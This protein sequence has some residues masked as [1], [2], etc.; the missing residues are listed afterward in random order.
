M[1]GTS[2]PVSKVV[3]DVIFIVCFTLLSNYQTSETSE[4]LL[5]QS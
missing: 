4:Y 2:E 3:N 1:V 5:K